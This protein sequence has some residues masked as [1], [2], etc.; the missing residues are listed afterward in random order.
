MNTAQKGF[1]LIE[2]MIVIAIIGILAAI[3]LP[4]YQTYTKKAIFSERNTDLLYSEIERI[5]TNLY[6]TYN[7]LIQKTGDIVQVPR[8]RP[9]SFIGFENCLYKNAIISQLRTYEQNDNDS[10]KEYL[11]IITRIKAFIYE[12]KADGATVGIFNSSIVARELGLSDKSDVETTIKG[13]LQVTEVS[14]EQA[15]EIQK[16]L[17]EQV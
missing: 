4:A 3:A 13:K 9:I 14:Y 2:L 15:K 5:F 8:E 16:K 10:Y 6:N 11:P 12:D 17:D 1:T 7:I